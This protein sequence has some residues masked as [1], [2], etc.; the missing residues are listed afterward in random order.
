MEEKKD[1]GINME[2]K[3]KTTRP[4]AA[5]NAVSNDVGGTGGSLTISGGKPEEE[6]NGG[7]QTVNAAETAATENGMAAQTADENVLTQ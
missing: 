4:A 5:G 3:E 2:E 7:A 1:S 6:I